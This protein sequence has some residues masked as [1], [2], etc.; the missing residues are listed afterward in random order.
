MVESINLL[1]LLIYL[2]IS[3]TVSPLITGFHIWNTRTFKSYLMDGSSGYESYG[4]FISISLTILFSIGLISFSS[5]LVF[6]AIG[7]MG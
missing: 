7:R 4:N 2:G 6:K 3:L 5:Y 1:D